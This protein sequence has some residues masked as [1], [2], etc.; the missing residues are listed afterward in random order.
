MS[1]DAALAAIPRPAPF[2]KMARFIAV[3]L[4]DLAQE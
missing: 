2:W 4:P 1:P 3:I